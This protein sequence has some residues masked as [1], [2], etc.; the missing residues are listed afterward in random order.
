VPDPPH[1]RR[2]GPWQWV[3]LATA[4]VLAVVWLV[5]AAART[6]S[7]FRFRTHRTAG[8]PKGD[9]WARVAAAVATVTALVTLATVALI[10]AM[11]GLVDSGFLGWLDLPVAQR[12][13]FHLP[14]ALIVLGG[15]TV[16]L[17][18]VGWVRHW[19]PRATGS[20][21]AGLAVAAVM[22]VAQIAAWH[23]IGWGLA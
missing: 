15:C 5:T 19:W 17:A 22:V 12:F 10:A 8:P 21:Y 23:L 4:A 20:S 1:P 3:T 13:A 2:R 9:L 6:L 7:R 11:P 18:A 14:A 16:A